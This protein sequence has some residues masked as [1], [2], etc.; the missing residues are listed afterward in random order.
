MIAYCYDA[1]TNQALGCLWRGGGP[2]G[3]SHHYPSFGRDQ[4]ELPELFHH[5]IA[6]VV[7]VGS[8]HENKI[9]LGVLC[10]KIV[11][12]AEDID[13]EDAGALGHL[14]RAQVLLDTADRRTRR[15][16]ERD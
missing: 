16:D 13:R 12:C 6:E 4:L 5:F 2:L 7:F 8:I 10:P 11:Q 14:H 3:L 1:G 15:I 9:E